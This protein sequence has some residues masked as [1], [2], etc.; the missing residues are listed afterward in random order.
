MVVAATL[1]A[2]HKITVISISLCHFIYSKGQQT[3]NA[4]CH[5]SL[6][7]RSPSKKPAANQNA[8]N[9]SKPI[10]AMLSGQPSGYNCAQSRAVQ[11]IEMVDA[12]KAL[13]PNPPQ[14]IVNLHYAQPAARVHCVSA[15]C[16][17]TI[18]S[19]PSSLRFRGGLVLYSF[20]VVFLFYVVF[21]PP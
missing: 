14:H 13:L 7:T 10:R 8:K 18:S 9:N 2:V 16:V 11:S 4:P 5:T 1:I 6:S 3:H 12:L 17:M 21:F 19:F 15:F 20:F